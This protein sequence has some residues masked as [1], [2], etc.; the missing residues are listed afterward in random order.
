MYFCYLFSL[1]TV[2]DRRHLFRSKTWWDRQGWAGSNWGSAPPISW[3]DRAGRAAAFGDWRHSFHSN[4]SQKDSTIVVWYDPSY[5]TGRDGQRRQRCSGGLGVHGT[6]PSLLGR[7]RATIFVINLIQSI[8]VVSN[9]C[10]Y[11][12]CTNIKYPL[13]L[14][15]IIKSCCAK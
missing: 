3:R 11:K 14:V 8:R 1:R 4:P 9:I 10:T 5:V 6:V 13:F 7:D 15:D 12:A 2:G